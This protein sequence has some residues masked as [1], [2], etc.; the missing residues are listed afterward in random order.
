[1]PDW[2]SPLTLAEM[3]SFSRPTAPGHIGVDFTAIGDDW[4][5]GTVPLDDRTRTPEGTLDHGAIAILAE[6]LASVGATMCVDRTR[7]ACLGQVLHLQHAGPLRQGPARGRARPL[8]VQ[9]RNQLWEIAVTDASGTPVCMAQLA[10][11]VVDRPAE[12][13]AAPT[14]GS[15]R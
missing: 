13:G 8:W 3:T 9:P 15:S 6:T 4:L 14:G 11:A 10:L 5:E 2:A 1:M 12:V 7:Q